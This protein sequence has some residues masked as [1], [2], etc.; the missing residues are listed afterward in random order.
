LLSSVAVMVVTLLFLKRTLPPLGV[1]KLRFER[2][3]LTALFGLGT[4]FVF[5]DLAMVLL[6]NVNATFLS[7]L[8][9]PEV[10]GW[11]GVSQRLVG[12]LIFPASALIGALY[13]TLCRLQTEDPAEF[14]RVSRNAIYGTALLAAPAAVGCGMFPE[15]G[16]SIFGNAKFGGASE[17]LRVMSLFVFLV[18]FSMPIGTTIL[19]SN[20]Q[21]AWALVQ[22]SCILVA[23]CGNPF[24]I[25][26]FQNLH[27]NGATGTCVTLV[28][29]ELFVVGCGV[30]LAPRGLFNWELGKSLLLAGFSGCAMAGVAWLTKPVSMFLAVPAAVLTYAGVA[31]F[32]GAVQPSTIDLLKG[33]INRKLLRR[34]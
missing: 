6:P 16:V 11:Y 4:P 1:G 15:L 17:H 19:A 13:P 29:S 3:A 24:L 12:L 18:Y 20:R 8:V 5:F 22:C 23:V 21:R 28:L 25:P 10:I 26:Y 30:A 33:F 27:G 34:A 14:T 32:S 7:K 9:P 2:N 31:Y